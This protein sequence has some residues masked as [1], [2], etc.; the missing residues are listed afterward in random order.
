MQHQK[1][2]QVDSPNSLR[3]SRLLAPSAIALALSSVLLAMP[4]TTYAEEPGSTTSSDT[5]PGGE[6]SI[7]KSVRKAAAENDGTAQLPTVTVTARQSEE[8]A[9]DIPFGLS[10]IGGDELETRRLQT[11]EEALRSTPGVNVNS[12]G[13]P[14]SANVLIRG[15]G[16]LNQ[17][18]M[19]DG[20]VVMNVDGVSM[21]MRN[22]ALGTLDVERVE[23][24]KGPQGTLFGGNSQAGAVN[25]TTRKP[26][27]SFEA[28]VRGEY[29][30]D[31]QH[32]EEAV[33]SG[34]LSERLSGRFAIRNTGSDHWIE[35]A[36]DG[37]PLTKPAN[38]A[39]RGSLLWDIASGTNMLF[40]AE[41]HENKRS[42]TITLLRPFGDPLS[43]DFTPGTF[44]GDHKIVERYSAEIN[45]DL[46]NSRITSITAYTSTDYVAIGGYDRRNMQ[47]LYGYPI[48]YL[49]KD[50]SD[51][52][53]LSQ[54]LRWSSL[55]GASIFWVTGLN[56]S[57][58]KRTFDSLYFFNGTRQERNYKTSSHAAYGEVTYPLTD[59]LKV[60]GGVRHSWDS[61][62]YD[63]K[64]YSTGVVQ[65][66]RELDD[67]YTTGRVALSYAFTPTT[68]VY[69]VLSRG[70]QSGGFSDFTTQISDSTPYKPASS[71]AAEL[72][73]KMESTDHRFALNAAL[74]FT[75]V[76]DAHLLGYDYTTFSTSA[77]NANTESKG[78][79]L[80]G[81]WHLDNGFT[82]SGGVSYID[83][84]I[85]S[86]AFGVNGGDVHSGSRMPDVPRWSGSLS[87]SHRKA[88]PGFLGLSSPVLN[89]QLSYQYVG[90]RTADAQNHFN[91]GS[92]QKVDTR[93]GLMTGNTEVYLYVNNLLDKQQDLYGY[94]A[95]PT[96]TQG[97]PA[98]GRT[99]G[100]GLSHYF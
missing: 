95:A 20:S 35:N 23:V 17:A 94:W 4:R 34:P 40:T 37:K 86:D 60:T 92:Y 77:I 45:H 7:Q 70:Y 88:L 36:Q 84:K 42:P 9:K 31:N 29:G 59:A 52:E 91:L 72:G 22:A 76:Q 53:V 62:T 15:S 87:V 73:F 3:C 41:R 32:L 13:D 83:A 46:A 55:P 1:A 66:N 54:D 27:R 80:E 10:V 90:T 61:K 8:R 30:Q 82:L 96:V 48:E 2:H 98:R 65:D 21:S 69:G 57:H 56:L 99:L 16:S 39:F 11:V 74:F 38:L 14:N 25:V 18:S 49:R 89:T 12:Y 44:D 67:T 78:A 51:Q 64:Y 19:D 33:V 50:S 85:T 97:A 26:T 5:I 47:A 100:V 58:S 93:I 81:S 71:N 43:L 63:A 79:E 75:K 68:N 24:L 28:Y 6:A